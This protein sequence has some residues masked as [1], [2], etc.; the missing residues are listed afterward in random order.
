[1]PAVLLPRL[2][3]QITEL[4][5]KFTRPN[6]FQSGLRELF[7]YYASR[8]YK[9]G[10]AT[11]SS[12]LVDSYHVPPLVMRQLEQEIT[13]FVI[14]NPEAALNI[15]SV[16]W[17]EDMLEPR[18]LTAIILGIVPSSL[19]ERVIQLL[20]S[21]CRTDVEGVSLQALLERGGQRL[22]HEKPDLWL[23]VVADWLS[24]S[25]ALTQAMGVRA[26]LTF[27]ND[28]DFVNLPAIFNLTGRPL[29]SSASAVQAEMYELITALSKRSAAETAYFLRQVL[30]GG[31]NPATIRVIRKALP[32]L[33]V[34]V[35]GPLRSA[36]FNLPTIPLPPKEEM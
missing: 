9:P 15:A 11:P 3:K 19:S 33:P 28:R 23:S 14:E 18:Q 2:K 4:T 36:L 13:P 12:R 24:S 21:W 10:K 31:A 17:T 7:S 5:W 26:L 35:Q 16:L 32:N 22:R 20:Q 25:D 34:S 1:M 6:E 8:V 30:S 29:Q 27:V